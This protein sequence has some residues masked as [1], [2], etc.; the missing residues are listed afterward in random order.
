MTFLQR[1]KNNC[2]LFQGRSLSVMARPNM[3]RIQSLVH[4]ANQ[5]CLS[6]TASNHLLGSDLVILF[7]ILLE[8]LGAVLCEKSNLRQRL[9][10][11]MPCQKTHQH[12]P[13]YTPADFRNGAL[14]DCSCIYRKPAGAGIP[15]C[16]GLFA[17]SM[18]LRAP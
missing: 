6:I 14:G 4:L 12:P 2:R 5:R 11:Q 7:P 17:T 9:A 1:E 18:F 10:N 16:K 3:G 15:D 8:P 13:D